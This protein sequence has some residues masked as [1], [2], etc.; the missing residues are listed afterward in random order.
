[1]EAG[2]R[3]EVELAVRVTNQRGVETSPGTA[4]VLLP[5]REHGPVTLPE[6]PAT[7]I[8]GMLDHE[9]DRLADPGLAVVG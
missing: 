3:C 4:V 8:P 7:D 1:T 2:P 6:P 5:S 9:I